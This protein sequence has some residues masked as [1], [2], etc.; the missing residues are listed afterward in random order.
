MTCTDCG[1]EMTTGTENYRYDQCG[2]PYVVL[3]NVQ[4]SRCQKCGAHEV[5]IV[6][7]EALHHFIAYAVAQKGTRLT[8]EELRFLRKYLG[9]SGSDFAKI[10]GVKPETVSRWENGAKPP[11]PVADRLVRMLAISTEPATRYPIDHS[12]VIKHLREIDG[13]VSEPVRVEAKLEGKEWAP[14]QA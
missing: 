9:F 7:L 1:S 6:G 13:T 12:K 14:A 10:V 3:E 11:S 5:S 4:V 8:Q 2:L